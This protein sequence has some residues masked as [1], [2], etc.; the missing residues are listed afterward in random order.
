MIND[1]PTGNRGGTI[2]TSKSDLERDQRMWLFDTL[3]A[4]YRAIVRDAPYNL[5]VHAYSGYLK[6]SIDRLMNRSI[7]ATYGEDHP[8]YRKDV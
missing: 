2:C 7:L 1:E 6:E 5:I 8:Q 4:E 3:P